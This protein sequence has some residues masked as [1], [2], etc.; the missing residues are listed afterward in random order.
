MEILPDLLLGPKVPKWRPWV[1]GSLH[2]KSSVSWVSSRPS[3]SSFVWQFFLNFWKARKLVFPPTQSESWQCPSGPCVLA[4]QNIF[5]M[6]GLAFQL[7]LE[8]STNLFKV[9]II[10]STLIPIRCRVWLFNKCKSWNPRIRHEV[11][12]LVISWWSVSLD[13]VILNVCFA[14]K[15]RAII[16]TRK[17]KTGWSKTCVLERAKWTLLPSKVFGNVNHGECIPRPWKMIDLLNQNTG[18]LKALLISHT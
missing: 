11:P 6:L 14:L 15:G 5:W 4:T 17:S 10:T 8:T 1:R 12:G 18:I 3:F 7:T 2:L 9:I 13:L 16:H